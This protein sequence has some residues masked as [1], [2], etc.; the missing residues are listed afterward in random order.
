VLVFEMV[1]KRRKPNL[2]DRRRATEWS[3]LLLE[4]YTKARHL[5]RGRK[6]RAAEAALSRA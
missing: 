2:K 3:Q 4:R 1:Q 6:E 5:P